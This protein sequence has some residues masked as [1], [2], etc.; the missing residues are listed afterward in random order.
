MHLYLKNFF[1]CKHQSSPLSLRD[2]PPFKGGWTFQAA[3]GRHMRKPSLDRE[4]ARQG[5]WDDFC[6]HCTCARKTL[7][8]ASIN[9]PPCRSATSPLSRV[10]GPFRRFAANEKPSPDGMMNDFPALVLLA[11]FFLYVLPM[12]SYTRSTFQ[13]SA[14]YVPCTIDELTW[15]CGPPFQHSEGWCP[16][17]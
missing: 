12:E 3:F 7:Y 16:V 14:S 11:G 13:Q 1:C 6:Y 2:I 17:S 15:P 8:A 5:G 4:G 10:D 9:L